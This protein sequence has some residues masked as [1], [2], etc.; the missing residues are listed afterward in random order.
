VREPLPDPLDRPPLPPR[1]YLAAD[2][3]TA[4]PAATPLAD[5]V[6]LG[7]CWNSAVSGLSLATLAGTQGGTHRLTQSRGLP[8]AGNEQK[9][10]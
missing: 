3:S 10:P 4:S 1:T 7:A 2:P 9:Q 8:P 5:Q 6:V